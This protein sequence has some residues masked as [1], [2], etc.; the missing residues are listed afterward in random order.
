MQFR[1]DALKRL[2]PFDLSIQP[3]LHLPRNDFL[4]FLQSLNGFKI[5]Q[6]MIKTSSAFSIGE[7]AKETRRFTK[8]IPQP[9]VIEEGYDKFNYIDDHDHKRQGILNLE[10][11]WRTLFWWKRVVY[12]CFWYRYY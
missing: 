2:P 6:N 11:G 8:V 3:N 5:Y 9:K 4:T 10:E 7:C 1:V 12:N